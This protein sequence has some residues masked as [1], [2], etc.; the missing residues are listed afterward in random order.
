MYER[1][2]KRTL[3]SINR[4]TYQN[5]LVIVLEDVDKDYDNQ[6][7]TAKQII[8]L[9]QDSQNYP[10]L[11]DKIAYSVEHC[12]GPAAA[13]IRIKELFL[14]TACDD[15]IAVM[16]DDDDALKRSDAIEDIVYMMNS[17][18]ANICI[19]SFESCGEISMDITNKGGGKHNE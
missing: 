16:L 3:D 18:K 12:G 14:K 8:S 11:F 1:N 6:V 2:L 19:T 17:R 15:D 7:T 5:I 9:Y 13:M 10:F 4:Q